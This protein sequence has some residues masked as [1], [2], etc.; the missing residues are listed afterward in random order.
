M[1]KRGALRRRPFPKLQ[2][3]VLVSSGSTPK[4]VAQ[5]LHGYLKKQKWKKSWPPQWLA[6]YKR[7][8][9]TLK[10]EVNCGLCA[11]ACECTSA[12]LPAEST[13]VIDLATSS[14]EEAVRSEVVPTPL[15]NVSRVEV[16]DLTQ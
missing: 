9:D 8:T 11:S 2:V 10:P 4:A 3:A 14:D 13:Q 7:I 16:V 15:Q 5:F 1:T 12:Q 6:T